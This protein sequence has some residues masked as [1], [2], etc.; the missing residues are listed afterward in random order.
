MD[1]KMITIT[2]R[3]VENLAEFITR[4]RSNLMAKEGYTSAEAKTIIHKSIIS[5]VSWHVTWNGYDPESVTK[6]IL[7]VTSKS[8]EILDNQCPWLN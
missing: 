6:E 3:I 1:E 2:A 7:R 5:I 8:K 4:V